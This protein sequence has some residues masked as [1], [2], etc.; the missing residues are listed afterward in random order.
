MSSSV[1]YGIA[2]L[3]NLIIPKKKNS[4]FAEPHKNGRKEKQDIINKSGDSVLAF[5][6]YLI[7]KNLIENKT[8]YLVT[9]DKARMAELVKYLSVRNVNNVTLL[10]HYSCSDGISKVIKKI[11]FN[12]TKM[13][14]KTWI[15]AT[16]HDSKRY[17]L[18]TQRLICLEYFSSFKSDYDDLPFDYLP[19]SWSLVCST[20]VLDSVT[21]SAAFAIPYSCFKPFGLCRN[22][23]LFTK[24][25][26][27]QTIKAWIRQHTDRDYEKIIIYA[28]TYRDYE[29]NEETK[30][31]VWG[32]EDETVINKSIADANA[33]VIA[34]MHSWQ[35]QNAVSHENKN[36]IF[37][38]P[39]YDFTIYDVMT[40]ADLMIT[41]YSSIGLDFILIDKPV[42][43]SLY[44]EQ[45]YL[46]TRGMCIEP[47][48]EICG[49]EIVRTADAL[50]SNIQRSLLEGYISPQSKRVKNLYFKYQDG[51]SCDR[52]YD[53]LHREETL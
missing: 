38:E 27:E 36:I 1:K 19:K 21:K 15:C 34:K 39:S 50:A 31:N 42:I 33:V 7:E 17:A 32:Y 52:V 14:C 48:E 53:Y 9:Y 20:S 28:P 13:R 37:Y 10:L 30:R 4:I 40:I 2:K 44:D 35:N 25:D 8:I 26:K 12:F 46:E 3:I 49:G 45:R 43:Y 23:V 29:E 6:D 47:I 11:A 5:L 18:K 41:D 16:V 51:R 22:D 24:T